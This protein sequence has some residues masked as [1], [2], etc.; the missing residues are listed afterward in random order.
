MHFRNSPY[1][2]KPCLA[3][4]NRV[5]NYALNTC[6]KRY[7]QIILLSIHVYTCANTKLSPQLNHCAVLHVHVGAFQHIH[8]ICKLYCSSTVDFYTSAY[9][10][11][12]YLCLIVFTPQGCSSAA[13]IV[14]VHGCLYVKGGFVYHS[15]L[16]T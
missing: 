10:I 1:L 4:N 6:N 7:N 14:S 3:Q 5:V 13:C 8:I 12:L 15:E 11:Y 2:S 16:R 9:F